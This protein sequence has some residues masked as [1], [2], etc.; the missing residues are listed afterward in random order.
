MSEPVAMLLAK[1]RSLR[2]ERDRYHTETPEIIRALRAAGI[3]Y[4][5]IRRETGIPDGT[6]ARMSG[7]RDSTPSAARS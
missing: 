7:T 2:A 6:A 5:R 1:A 4:S 3:P